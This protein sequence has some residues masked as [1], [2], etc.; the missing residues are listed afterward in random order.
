MDLKNKTIVHIAQYAAPY[1]GNFI[2]SLNFLE[3][4]LAEAGCKMAFVFPEKA[5]Q[6]SWWSNFAENHIVYNTRNDVGNSAQELFYIFEREKP[7]IVH[8]HFEGYDI[9]TKI[10]S[11]KFRKKYGIAPRNVWHL[12]DY[13]TYVKNPIKKLYQKWCFFKHY[14]LNAKEVA[15]IGVCDEI[16][17]FV[18]S[19]KKLS[20][21]PFYAEATIPNG[22]DLSRI[23]RQ[24]QWSG[25]VK[26]FLAYG[27]RNVQKR[28]DVILRAF[29]ILPTPPR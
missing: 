3:T 23:N 20:G 5:K 19:Y 11:E 4:S 2:K 18:S 14:C 12:H 24:K 1:E 16:R 26:T 8:T 27:G 9:P 7:T 21:K 25:N 10:A 13:F 17:L 15:V 6:Q 29:S 28:I 22:I